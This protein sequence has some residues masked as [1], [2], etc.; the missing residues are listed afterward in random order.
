MTLLRDIEQ[1]ALAFATA[2]HHGQVRKY[3]GAAYVE[4]CIAVANMV[5]ERGGSPEVVAAALLH[6]TLEDTSTSMDELQREFGAITASLVDEVTD[7]YT[8]IGYPHL[9]RKQR[10]NLE[11]AR[12]GEISTSAKLIKLCDLIDNT[13]S[14][15]EHDPD[16]AVTY[17]REKADTLEA[18]GYGS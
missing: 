15:V 17:L 13:R 10:K 7:E 16:F 5:R 18:M 2:K 9:N 8:K 3:T 14:I 11:V 4:H 6:D 1:K 12:L